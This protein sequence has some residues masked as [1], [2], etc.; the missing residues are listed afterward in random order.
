MS[1]KRVDQER[2]SLS[3]WMIDPLI[4]TAM[5]RKSRGLRQS[6]LSMADVGIQQ[7][8]VITRT[9]A[10]VVE[11]PIQNFAGRPGSVE[12]KTIIREN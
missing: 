2:Q 9:N 10:V 5:G 3:E 8:L 7:T 12:E 6:D 4:T 1:S 11:D